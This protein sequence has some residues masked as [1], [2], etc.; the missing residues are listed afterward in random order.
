MDGLVQIDA[1][2]R[3]R[4]L[5]S[6][7]EM[8]MSLVRTGVPLQV[9]VVSAPGEKFPGEVY[10][11]APAL[12]PAN[13][14]LLIKAWVPNAEHKMRP[15]MFATIGVEI[16]RHDQA[17]VVPETALAYDTDGAYIWR[18]GTDQMAERVRVTAGIR[19]TG[20]VEITQGLQAGDRIVSAGSHKVAPNVRLRPAPTLAPQAAAP[21][22]AA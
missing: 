19:R 11:V 21:K 6:V 16:A 7:P 13:R 22:P 4:L 20:R 15:G 10:F 1:I 2:D 12:D 17:L 18:L 14:R 5:F 8:A 9:G 3:L